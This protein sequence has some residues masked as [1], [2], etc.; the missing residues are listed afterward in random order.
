MSNIMRDDI[1]PGDTIKVSSSGGGVFVTR[2]GT[3]ALGPLSHGVFRTAEGSVL[4]D[5]GWAGKYSFDLIDRPKPKLPQTH[6][7]IVIVDDSFGR[8]AAIILRS[9]RWE[10]LQGGVYDL[11]QLHS[12]KLAKVVEVE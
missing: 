9:G 8:G 12:W 5:G 1:R 7:S 10:Y 4:W 6:G 3:V 11:N 2:T